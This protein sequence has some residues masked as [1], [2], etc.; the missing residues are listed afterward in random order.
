MH[1]QT[2]THA[3]THTRFGV[4][5]IGGRHTTTI[6]KQNSI[7]A[8][9]SDNNDNNSNNRLVGSS[10]TGWNVH[11]VVVRVQFNRQ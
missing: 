5:C 6:I 8:L 1:A 11:E 4:E 2:R 7:D 3:R 9:F 10:V